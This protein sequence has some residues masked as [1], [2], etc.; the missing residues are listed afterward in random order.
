MIPKVI[1]LHQTKR[2]EGLVICVYDDAVEKFMAKQRVESG[3]NSTYL[4][5]VGTG[6]AMPHR[7]H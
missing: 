6:R 3:N 1:S 5:V 2:K 7:I 4:R